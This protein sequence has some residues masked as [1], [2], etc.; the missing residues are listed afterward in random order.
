MKSRQIRYCCVKHDKTLMVDKLILFH[1][2]TSLWQAWQKNSSIVWGLNGLW[3]MQGHSSSGY[4]GTNT[5][6]C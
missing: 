1:A 6:G 2:F 3:E 5:L 4:T